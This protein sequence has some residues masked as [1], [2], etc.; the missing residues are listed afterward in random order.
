LDKIDFKDY[1]NTQS[2]DSLSNAVTLGISIGLAKN[3]GAKIRS[4][5]I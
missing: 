4:S 5:K 3:G 1:L 2:L